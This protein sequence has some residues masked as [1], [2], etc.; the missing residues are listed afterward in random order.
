[1]YCSKESI[2]TDLPEL[3][4]TEFGDFIIKKELIKD[5]DI[6]DFHCHLFCSIESMVPRI[7][8]SSNI[9][10]NKSFFDLSCYPIATKF[11]D[12]DKVLYT[13]YPSRMFSLDGLK[14]AYEISGLGGFLDALKKSTPERLIRDMKL[15]NI[16]KS[17]VLQIN[18][19]GSQS[20]DEINN[21]NSKYKELITFG[22]IDPDDKDMMLKFEK[23]LTS[24]IKGWKLAP[25]ISGVD[26]DSPQSI[27]LLQLYKETNLPIIS[28]SG[29]AFP[30]DMI[31]KIPKKLKKSI[32]TQ[33]I[34][35]FDRVLKE[36]PNIKFV[37]A[38]GGLYQTDELIEIMKK[39]PNTFVE[40]ST[41]TSANIQKLINAVGDERI[42][43]GTD[44][45]AFNHCMSLLSV[46][47]AT[48][49]E[50][51]RRNILYNNAVE[52]L[53]I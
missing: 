23:A 19:N 5:Y 30:L 40:I 50:S 11:F 41:Q 43:Y 46:L 44:Y 27:K 34:S 14:L 39:H 25:H 24:D 15:N 17:V 8:R 12:F 35:R 52:L 2:L 22:S 47:R 53:N 20:S 3:E 42:M 48:E 10:Y 49:S 38:H 33:D 9:D 31:W 4:L 6:I 16:K 13:D 45:P 36:V 28:C 1:M 37:F 7:F 26:I 51:A 21:I 32:M 18:K 29:L